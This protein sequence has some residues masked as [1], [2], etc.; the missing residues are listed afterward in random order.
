MEN[1]THLWM[2]RPVDLLLH[3]NPS[4]PG[5]THLLRTEFTATAKQNPPNESRI[6]SLGIVGG[7][8]GQSAVTVRKQLLQKV[9]FHQQLRLRPPT[10]FIASIS[11]S[12]I[13]LICFKMRTKTQSLGAKK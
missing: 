9:S 10:G 6:K 13:F 7:Q 5:G 1:L 8:K 4:W 2:S 12:L 3:I 11:I